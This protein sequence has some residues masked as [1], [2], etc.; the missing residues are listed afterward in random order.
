MSRRAGDQLVAIMCWAQE[1]NHLIIN[2]LYVF[3]RFCLHRAQLDQVFAGGTGVRDES[4]PLCHEGRAVAKTGRGLSRI[5]G[6]PGEDR[7]RDPWCVAAQPARSAA[8]GRELPRPPAIYQCNQ[9]QSS[10]CSMFQQR[11]PPIAVSLGTS[12]S[13]A[14]ADGWLLSIER[15]RICVF[16]PGAN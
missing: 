2:G 15:C 5:M 13:G 12:V 11:S 10:N 16:A 1:E 4:L 8:V 9:L 3:V 14:A 7:G 6:F